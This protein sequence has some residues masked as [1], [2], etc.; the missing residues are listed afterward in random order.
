LELLVDAVPVFP[1]QSVQ[2]K[3]FKAMLHLFMKVFYRLHDMVSIEQDSTFMNFEIVTQ[4]FSESKKHPEV[5]RMLFN[6]FAAKEV[7]GN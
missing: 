5:S 2:R 6:Y 4:S 3:S 1:V 7:V